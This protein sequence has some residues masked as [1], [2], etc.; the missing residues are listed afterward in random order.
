MLKNTSPRLL[1]PV[2]IFVISLSCIC[3]G[4]ETLNARQLKE[5]LKKYPSA[6][7]NRDG[8]LSR[9]EALNFRKKYSGQGKAKSRNKRGIKREFKVNPGWDLERFPD[10]ATCYKSPAEIKAI[11]EKATK[12]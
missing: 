11:F 7:T 10:H 9:Y 12:W 5:L 3:S 4:Q 8:T 2:F 1:V 6:D